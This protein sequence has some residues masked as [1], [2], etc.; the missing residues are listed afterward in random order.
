MSWHALQSIHNHGAQQ[1]MSKSPQYADWEI[2]S[3]FYSALH[4]V[5]EYLLSIG[6]KPRNHQTRDR[7]VDENI[8]HAYQDYYDLYNLCL[9]VRYETSYTDVS[10][11]DR[12]TAIYL[13][14]SIRQK[15]QIST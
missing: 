12:K 4:T 8:P 9:K 7:M 10:E 11:E 2:T 3:L 5:D 13:H 6:K 1:H 14:N 15:L